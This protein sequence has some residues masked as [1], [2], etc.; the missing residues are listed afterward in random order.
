MNINIGTFLLQ[1]AA[2]GLW[3]FIV[4]ALYALWEKFADKY[5]PGLLDVEPAGVSQPPS[6]VP[7]PIPATSTDAAKQA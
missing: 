2:M 3:V 7:S 1:C 5:F 6:P 4:A